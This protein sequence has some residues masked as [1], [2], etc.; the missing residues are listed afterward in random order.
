MSSSKTEDLSIEGCLKSGYSMIGEADMWRMQPEL[1][2]EPIIPDSVHSIE[3]LITGISDKLGIKD[4]YETRKTNPYYEQV[5]CC[6]NNLNN[7]F[8]INKPGSGTASNTITATIANSY[9]GNGVSSL[10]QE[11]H[12]VIIKGDN[13]Q[14]LHGLITAKNKATA[15]A[16]TV[17]IQLANGAL[18]SLT[19]AN[20]YSVTYD[21]MRTYD[22][23][24][25]I[26]GD[27]TRQNLPPLTKG[28]M[29]S[30]SDKECISTSALTGMGYTEIPNGGTEIFEYFNPITKKMERSFMWENQK[31][32][33]MDGRE[34]LSRAHNLLFGK[35]D[36]ATGT[37]ID[38]IVTVAR[39]AGKNGGNGRFRDF[40]VLKAYLM[41][42]AKKAK[43]DNISKE[44]MILMD[45]DFATSVDDS[46]SKIVGYRDN[47]YTLYGSQV[48]AQGILNWYNFKMIKNIFG[49]GI[50]IVFK[51]MDITAL[52][53][54]A[55]VHTNFAVVIPVISYRDTMGNRVPMLQ[56]TKPEIFDPKAGDR[57]WIIDKR[58]ISA[59]PEIEINRQAHY[60]LIHRCPSH[61]GFLDGN[62]Y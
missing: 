29:A 58:D 49:L 16:H 31:K 21:P 45:D 28:Y 38:G 7:E 11:K 44:V 34:T 23:V 12:Q 50:D 4:T 42:I 39:E 5:H 60:G 54:L 56:L 61:Y 47:G 10:P 55:N 13:G 40:S 53:G 57:T 52:G 2:K 1:R 25:C 3:A 27:S 6:T 48:E 36:I 62:Q 24:T 32:S 17:T 41:R 37:G 19:A 33:A 8:I 59:C 20:Q 26:V 30:F 9:S 18:A 35:R 51:N 46:I 22:N 43:R 14:V 15:N